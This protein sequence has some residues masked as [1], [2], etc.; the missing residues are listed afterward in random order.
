MYYTIPGNICMKNFLEMMQTN[1][2]NDFNI[3]ICNNIEIV[4]VGQPHNVNGRDAELAPSLEPHEN[5][6]FGEKYQHT[7]FQNLGFYIR[8]VPIVIEDDEE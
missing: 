3:N 7:N 5:V 8:A 2:R 4:E 1:A 6:T